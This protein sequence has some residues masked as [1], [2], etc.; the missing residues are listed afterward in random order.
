MQTIL[1]GKPLTFGNIEQ[2]STINSL[3]AK[4]KEKDLREKKMAAGEL[5]EFEVDLKVEGTVTIC[6]KASSKQHAIDIAK[7][8]I[9]AY[10]IDIDEVDVDECR[11]I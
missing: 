1:A 3:Q 10:G 6:V 2:I 8:D 5:V 4:E 9:D 7:A 11:A